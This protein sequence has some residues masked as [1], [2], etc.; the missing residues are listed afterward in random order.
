[1]Q[2]RNILF[3]YTVLDL[4]CMALTDTGNDEDFNTA[5]EALDGYF[6]PSVNKP[7]ERY[8]L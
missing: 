4:I 8:L 5:L 3:C 6:K 1:M 7:Y 2:K